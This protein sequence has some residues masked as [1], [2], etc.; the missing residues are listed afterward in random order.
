MSDSRRLLLV[1]IFPQTRR[2]TFTAPGSPH[3]FPLE[4]SGC[5][6]P[7]DVLSGKNPQFFLF[8]H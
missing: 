7:E 4:K 1:S 5:G 2:V 8:V 6:Y 3:F